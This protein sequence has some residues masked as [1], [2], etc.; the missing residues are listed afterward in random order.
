MDRLSILSS[1]LDSEGLE[2]KTD[3][4]LDVL[5]ALTEVIPGT[6]L[7][8]PALA[9]VGQS[10]QKRIVEFIRILEDQVRYMEDSFLKDRVSREEFGDLFRE[11]CEQAERA[12][13]NFRLKCLAA[14]VKNGL[15]SDD[16]YG[17]RQRRFLALMREIN[18][19]EVLLL[20]L[21]SYAAN[22]KQ[23][24]EFFARYKAIFEYER[25]TFGAGEAV[26]REAYFR[27][28]CFDRLVRLNLVMVTYEMPRKGE[29][30]EFDSKTGHLRMKYREASP[31]GLELLDFLSLG[32]DVT[33]DKFEY[34]AK[35]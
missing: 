15:T 8:K 11:A 26:G 24:G 9:I 23:R 30:P 19:L 21:Q 20:K 29:A 12:R 1:K 16:I 17:L 31:L 33:P 28:D 25:M 14:A 6:K 3:I 35:G 2:K 4:L 32:R 22:P 10:R 27:E 18:D 7:L 5:E 13:S 34:E